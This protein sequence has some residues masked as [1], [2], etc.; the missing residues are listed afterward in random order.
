MCYSCTN[1]HDAAN[2]RNRFYPEA[3]A[4][5]GFAG[6][7]YGRNQ[8][9][10]QCFTYCM[11]RETGVVGSRVDVE[12]RCEPTCQEYDGNPQMSYL[13]DKVSCC[14]GNLCNGSDKIITNKSYIL[15][16]SLIIYFF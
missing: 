5:C 4:Q 7:F 11:K 10:S 15:L 13:I 9:K 6:E 2:S 14:V 16:L 8:Q 12:R 3:N 1:N